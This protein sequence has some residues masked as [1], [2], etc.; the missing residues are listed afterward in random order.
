MARAIPFHYSD[1]HVRLIVWTVC[2]LEIVSVSDYRSPDQ[3]R[4]YSSGEIS[5]LVQQR[6]V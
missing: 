1:P 4:E 2:D 5:D 3:L 6:P